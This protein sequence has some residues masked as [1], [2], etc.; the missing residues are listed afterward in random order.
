[1]FYVHSTQQAER[2]KQSKGYKVSIYG[3]KLLTIFCARGVDM[4]LTGLYSVSVLI[5]FFPLEL[6][7][8]HPQCAHSK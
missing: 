4:F 2:P 3:D 6:S 8:V 7:A 1:M 5:R